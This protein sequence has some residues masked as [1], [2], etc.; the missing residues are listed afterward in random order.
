MS[1]VDLATLR[2][3]YV[4][5]QLSIRSVAAT[6]HVDPS[7]VHTA[8]IRGRIAR[9]QRRER[10]ATPTERVARGQLDEARLRQLYLGEQRSI[11]EIAEILKTCTATV[12]HA[13]VAWNIPRR[14]RGRPDKQPLL[15]REDDTAEAPATMP[16]MELAT[17]MQ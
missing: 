4:D 11:R 7:T 17:E 13:L 6:L 3:L 1:T 2:H 8:L 10:R 14:K 12:H 16:V 9:R 5:E 15:I